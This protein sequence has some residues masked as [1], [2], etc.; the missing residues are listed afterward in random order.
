MSTGALFHDEMS[1][2]TGV[3]C[4]FCN[5]GASAHP[6][7]AF[8]GFCENH[9]PPPLGDVRSIVPP[10]HRTHQNGQQSGYMLHRR[11]VCCHPGGRRGNT[12]RVVAQWRHPVASGEA[13]VMLHWEMRSVCWHRCTAMAIEV[14]RN[15]GAFVC[16][17]RLFRLL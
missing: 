13:L 16:R 9:A 4:P 17:H 10:H 8:S 2:T 3:V 7:V 11:F 6:M 5:I 1:E 14:A 12:E 15:G